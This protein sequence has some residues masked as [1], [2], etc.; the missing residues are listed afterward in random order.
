MSVGREDAEKAQTD[1]KEKAMKLDPIRAEM[2][3]ALKAMAQRGF[4]FPYT[5]DSETTA[6]AKRKAKA[7]LKAYEEAYGTPVA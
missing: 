1:Q 4:L 3:E 6:E 2:Y 5:S 7:A